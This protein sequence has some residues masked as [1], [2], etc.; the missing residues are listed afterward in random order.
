LT[1][2]G[3]AFGE[4]LIAETVLPSGATSYALAVA[5]GS[6]D[7]ETGYRVTI[8]ADRPEAPVRI[9]NFTVE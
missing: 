5:E 8:A 2:S 1:W 4:Y 3:L 6:G 9:Y 7:P